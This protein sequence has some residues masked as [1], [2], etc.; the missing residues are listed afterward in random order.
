M[1]AVEYQHFVLMAASFSLI[2]GLALASFYSFG[3]TRKFQ[4]YREAVISSNDELLPGIDA[5]CQGNSELYNNLEA[6]R[7]APYFRLYSVDILA[8]CEYMP[9]EL[10]ECYTE[11][12]EILPINEED[13]PGN[14]LGV[15]QQEAIFE[16]DGWGRWDMLIGDY[17]DIQDY[18]EGYTG[19]DGS[20][21]WN[22]I[23]NRICFAGY[24]YED[25]HW[26]AVFNKAVSGLHSMI[27]AQVILS[28]KEKIDNNEPF[29][30]TEIWNDPTVEFQRRLSST[31]LAL[32][33]MF[34]SYMLLIAAVSKAKDRLMQESERYGLPEL[35][36]VFN[37]KLLLNDL[38][39]AA[40]SRRMQ[41][42]VSTVDTTNLWE[43]RMR[44]RELVRI[45]NCVQCNKCRLHGKISTMGLS[46][47]LKLLVGK[48]GHG[49]DPMRIHR[50]ELATL[51]TTLHK[52]SRTVDFSR[53]ML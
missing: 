8:S 16:L 1:Y 19:Y 11:G 40:P 21:I 32:E 12:C 3:K 53:S 14:I 49:E 43:A 15:D 6:L 36:N 17:Y 39:T 20:S 31:P 48:D 47:A 50:V 37:S 35:Q 30:E 25:N 5:I 27:S 13:V 38:A 29:Q 45:M 52:F 28:I 2:D 34:F 4:T 9:Q 24:S 7:E 23:H 33:N 42:L 44:T 41:M 26:K 22:Y 10:F 18:P 46:T 51:V